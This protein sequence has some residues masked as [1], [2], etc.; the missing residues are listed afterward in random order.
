[1]RT[2]KIHGMLP[3]IILVLI[4][5]LQLG[6]EHLVIQIIALYKIGLVLILKVLGTTESISAT[7]SIMEH[8]AAELDLDP[9]QVRLENLSQT[10]PDVE[11]YMKELIEWAEVDKRKKEVEDFNKVLLTD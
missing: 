3:Y 10:T 2:I 7:E 9:V 11:K 4:I 1:M 5:I 8:I 6:A